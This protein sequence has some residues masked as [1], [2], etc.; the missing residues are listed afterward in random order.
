VTS[1]VL[2]EPMEAQQLKIALG[3][4]LALACT[5]AFANDLGRMD[6]SSRYNETLRKTTNRDAEGQW[7]LPVS[8]EID[9]RAT[10]ETQQNSGASP[11]MS[12]DN[13]DSEDRD[14][15]RNSPSFDDNLGNRNPSLFGLKLKF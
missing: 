15:F 11:K 13:Y 14:K 10:N 4:L 12:F 6:R 5:F 7:R 2:N 3:L 8:R 9:W 1:C